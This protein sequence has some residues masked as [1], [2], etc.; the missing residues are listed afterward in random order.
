MRDADVGKPKDQWKPP[1]GY[2]PALGETREAQKAKNNADKKKINAVVPDDD[3][4]SDSDLSEVGFFMNALRPLPKILR[5]PTSGPINAMNR[6]NGLD[7]NQDYDPDVLASLNSWAHEVRVAPAKVKKSV[8]RDPKLDRAVKYI[9]GP[10]KANDEPN[11]NSTKDHEAPVP[12]I[13]MNDAPTIFLKSEKDLKKH[14]AAVM[15]L[16]AALPS[17]PKKL[18]KTARKIGTSRA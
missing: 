11:D 15:K 13:D 12:V 10:T 4:D 6:F 16:M 1:A 8:T 2:K 5:K 18:A 7:E 17:N 9:N 3:S 14:E